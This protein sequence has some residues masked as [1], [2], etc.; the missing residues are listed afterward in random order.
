M[1][2]YF[3]NNFMKKQDFIKAVANKA[4]ISQDAVSKVLGSM[5]E[6]IVSELKAGNEVNIT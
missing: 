1:F 2:L 4:L 5:I 3:N 6:V